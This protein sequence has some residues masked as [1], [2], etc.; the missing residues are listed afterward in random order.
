MCDLLLQALEK[1]V[2]GAVQFRLA[3][4]HGRAFL[5]G[6]REAVLAARRHA[7]AVLLPR[8]LHRNPT[9]LKTG[10]RERK[11]EGERGLGS[12]LYSHCRTIDYVHSSANINGAQHAGSPS[13]NRAVF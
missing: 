6:A 9:A 12:E 1:G 2:G 13:F 8:H 4:L 7:R 10:E 3:P 11:R 5:A